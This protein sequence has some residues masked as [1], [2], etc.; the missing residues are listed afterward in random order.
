M[1]NWLLVLLVLYVFKNKTCVRIRNSAAMLLFIFIILSKMFDL[2]CDL[3]LTGVVSLCSLTSVCLLTSLL[4]SIIF[5]VHL[6]EHPMHARPNF[7]KA[8]KKIFSIALKFRKL[9][10]I[11]D[12]DWLFE[13]NA[14][15]KY[16]LV[17]L[18][19]SKS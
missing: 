5:K 16:Y 4:K 8:L 7:F 6:E 3:R 19:K 9:E 1:P 10:A 17:S 15:L 18:L 11:K 2:T 12:E 14:N 13:L